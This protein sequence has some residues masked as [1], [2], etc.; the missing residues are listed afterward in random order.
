MRKNVLVIDDE[1]NMRNLLKIYLSSEYTIYEASDAKEAFEVLSIEDI[2]AIILDIM[3]PKKDGWEICREI[4]L[5]SQIPILMLTALDELKDKVYGLDIGADDYMVKPFEPAELT[6][7]M[8]ALLRRVNAS[9][10][11]H[12]KVLN[13]KHGLLKIEME[14]REVTVKGHKIDL[15]PKEFKLLSLLATSPKRVFTRDLLLDMVWGINDVLD[16]RTVDTH[17]KNIRIKVKKICPSYNPIKTVWGVGY[18]FNELD[19]GR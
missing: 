4:R 11:S 12:E 8:K 16:D 7:R 1:W 18:K 14:A 2:Q 6:A 5:R 9:D 3:L 10:P 19:E 15:T 13:F 17:V